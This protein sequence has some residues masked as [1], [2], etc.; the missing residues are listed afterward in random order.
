MQQSEGRKQDC[1][2]EV[3]QT[4]RN[5]RRGTRQVVLKC[6]G[7]QVSE[8]PLKAGMFPPRRLTGAQ[9][10]SVFTVPRVEGKDWGPPSYTWMAKCQSLCF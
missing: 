4:L 7:W 5:S 6:Q 3:S 10:V 8:D 1:K 2:A 9:R